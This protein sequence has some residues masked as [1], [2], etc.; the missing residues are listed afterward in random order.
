MD[1]KTKRKEQNKKLRLEEKDYDKLNKKLDKDNKS[2]NSKN[3]KGV[4]K[5]LSRSIREYKKYSVLSPILVSGEVV[6]EVLIPTLMAKLIDYGITPGNMNYVLKMGLILLAASFASL[7]FGVEAGRV[8]SIASA[9]FAKNLRHDMYYNVQNFAFSN[10]D[11]FSTAS[12][13]TRLTTDVTNIQ[14]AY[15]MII[16]MAVRTP[17]MFVFSII[18]AIRINMRLSLI[19][20]AILPFIIAAAALLFSKVNPLFRRI[21][22]TYDKLNSVVEENVRGI[23]VVKSYTREDH[24]ISKFKSISQK[25][26]FDFKRAEQ[27]MAFAMPIMQIASYAGIILISWF[28]AEIIVNTASTDLTT[29]GLMSMFTYCT[30]ILMSLIFL[31]VL[32]VQIVMS[33]TSAQRCVEIL[34]EKTDIKEPETPILTVKDGSID[35]ED[36]CFSYSKNSERKNALDHVSVHIGSGET[37]G[38]IGATGSS[39]STF[40]QLIPRLYDA[41]SG[42]VKVG[43][44]N[45][46]DYSL[47]VLRDNVSVVLQK[48]VLFSGTISDNIRWGDEN[49]ADEEVK[50]VC[51]LA[52]ADEFIEKFPDKYNTYIDQGG[53]NVSGGQK[54]RLCIARALLKKP[55]ILIMDDSTSAVDTATDAKIR[56]AMRTEIPDT[57]K[58]I[59]AQR[60]NSVQDADKIIVL[61]DG[62]ISDVG[63]HEELLKRSAIYSE[64]YHSQLKGGDENA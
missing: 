17:L 22:K 62:K 23:R 42:N 63:T 2:E 56:E 39:K 14:N 37:V 31:A 38:I 20:L 32:F 9:G 21:F 41:S 61:D 19:F 40:V 35:F 30:Q 46:K 7:F 15:M 1:E 34:E 59:I 10:I 64:V 44:V 43:G 33:R 52:Q 16:R 50:K 11:K 48:N 12:I 8:S 57:T 25:I 26:Y 28:G 49:A 45:V 24:E 51:E 53:A 29:G 18:F 3:N 36:V 55:K 58:I 13:V 4:I 54:Q 6:M 60:I 5:K 47:E 27:T